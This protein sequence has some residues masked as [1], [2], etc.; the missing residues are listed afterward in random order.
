MLVWDLFNQRHADGSQRFDPAYD[1]ASADAALEATIV[2]AVGGR[3]AEGGAALVSA[4]P[5]HGVIEAPK[6]RRPP[7][8]RP[9]RW[10][11]GMLL[12]AQVSQAGHWHTS[13][14]VAIVR[15]VKAAGTGG[16]EAQ[17]ARRPR[18]RADR[19]GR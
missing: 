4:D 19:G 6:G 11:P 14:A 13:G 8:G 15:P 7:G 2:T 9:A 17:A 16:D 5:A 3:L 10:L 18:R 1:G 12:P